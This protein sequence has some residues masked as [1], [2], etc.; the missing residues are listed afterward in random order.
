M[1]TH[2]ALTLAVVLV[3]FCPIAL[4]LAGPTQVTSVEGITEYRL[5][6][7]LKV[8]LFPDDSKPTVTVNITYLVG[9]RHEGY[10]ET[11][12]AHLLEHLMFKGTP[13]HPQ[14]WKELQDHGAQFNGTT[15]LDRTNYFE[16]L[17]ATPENLDFALR[18]E[19]DRMVNSFIAQKDLDSEMTVVRNE[20]EIGENDPIG[21]LSER[22]ASTAYLWHNYGKS[23]IGS[24]EDIERV[25]IDRLQAFYRK[26][27]QPDNA[28]LVVAGKFDPEKT[29]SKIDEI[30]GKIPRPERTL[31]TTYTVEPP[32]DGEREVI[33]RRVGDTQ[34]IGCAYHICA[35]AHEDTAPLQVLANVLTADQTGRLY[36]ALVEPQLA[37]SVSASAQVLCEPGLLEIMVQART[38]KPTDEIR[39]R[40]LEV[41]DNLGSQ[42]F[43]DE[44][45]NRAKAA[46]ARSF[47]LM[48]TDSQRVAIRLTDSA[49]S[50]DWRL[51]FLMRDRI[52]AV[53]PGDVQR[54]A[55]QYLRPSNRTIGVFLPT[56]A[57]ERTVVPETPDLAAI[58]ENY[59]GKE[60]VAK[61]AAFEPTYPNID[62]HTQRVTLPFG[63]QLAL[64]PKETRGN[65][66]S[67]ALSFRFG[68]EADLR[69]KAEAASMVA[70]MLMRGTTKHTRRQIQ[71][72]FA[73]L[74][75][76]VRIGAS[77]MMGMM[78]A[79]R[80]GA[81]V[82]DASIETTRDNLPAVLDLVAEILREPAFPKDE[83]EK[84]QKETIAQIEQQKSEPMMLALLEIQRRLSPWP[85]EDPRYVPTPEER[86]EAIQAVSLDE[87]KAIYAELIGAS[88]SQ[89]AAVGDF[90]P[91]LVTESLTKLFADWK[92]GKPYERIPNPYREVAAENVVL[93]TPDKASAM[94]A[95][96]M[97]IRMQDDDPDYPALFMANYVLGGSMNSRLM[98]RIRQQEG[99]SYGCGSMVAAS[100]QDESGTFL[101]FAMCAPQNTARALECAK[102]EIS[103][104]IREGLTAEELADAKKGY[105][106]QLEVMLANDRMLVAQLSSNLYLD[107]TMEFSRKRLE[108]IEALTAEEIRAAAE[109]YLAPDRFVVV[110]A[111]DFE[112]EPSP[113]IER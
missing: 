12:M 26:F 93:S 84:L 53:T 69:G 66:V 36:K 13:A 23:T 98:N 41:L 15:W 108:R 107:R 24:R 52:A 113:A 20:F 85:P 54:V 70:P 78:A 42:S 62:A 31:E 95:V 94:F 99:L 49:A 87:V 72:R 2:R 96:G 10:G 14:I 92:S 73:E 103:R 77:G 80:S 76:Q 28:V 30:Y 89:V 112:G 27:Y 8:L 11:G 51:L 6:N 82:L 106:Q 56:G 21:I 38:D 22:I 18:L 102:E 32:Q 17:S 43:T 101:A 88:A 58:L 16:T 105:R 68:S 100:P 39:R 90:D 7:G 104:L 79:L 61:G 64:L 46:F 111:G 37:T 57:P 59:R 45:V 60:V 9:S 29:L 65:A 34:A 40:L 81:G 4:S 97:P 5:D 83:F 47:A 86:I 33:L 44:E 19:A 109:K 25:P 3:I 63:M 74:K 110:S 55:A 48:M 71:D 1:K 91:A 75:A 50:G 67:V 35:A